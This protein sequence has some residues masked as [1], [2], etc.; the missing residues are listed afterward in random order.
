M[1]FISSAQGPVVVLIHGLFGDLDNLKA[2]GKVLESQ[3]QVLRID[4]PNHGKSEHGVAMDYPSLAKKVIDLLDEQGI[5]SVHLVGHSMGG[6]IAMAMA[7]DFP[8]RINSI[9]IADIAPVAYASSNTKHVLETI[10]SVPLSQIKDRREAQAYLM[11]HGVDGHTAL[12]LLKSLVRQNQH[13]AWKMDIAQLRQSYNDIIDW[14]YQQKKYT[15]PSLCIRG[16]QSDY[17]K[18]EYTNDIVRQFPTIQAKTILDA[19]H[20]L[21][22]QKPTFFNRLVKDFIDKQSL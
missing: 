19:G 12:F 16:E 5:D 11:K 20:W 4:V 15:G 21:H 8:T 6:K 9:V 18:K 17:V 7:L 2:L 1:H 14:P 13:F 22:A 3:Y 10:L